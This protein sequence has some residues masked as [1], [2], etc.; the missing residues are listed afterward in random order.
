MGRRVGL[1][2]KKVVKEEVEEVKVKK[3]VKPKET[4]KEEE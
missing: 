2:P 1:I 3:E 4:K